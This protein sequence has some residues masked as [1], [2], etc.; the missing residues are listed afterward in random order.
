MRTF[1][2]D[3]FVANFRDGNVLDLE[4]PWL[5]QTEFSPTQGTVEGCTRTPLYQSAFMVPWGMAGI[6]ECDDE[7]V[8]RR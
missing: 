4:V 2:K 1:E 5:C 6:S 3:V 7:V 8:L